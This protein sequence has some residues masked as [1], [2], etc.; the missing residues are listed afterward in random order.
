MFTSIEIEIRRPNVLQ[1]E[2]SRDFLWQKYGWGVDCSL[3]ESTLQIVTSLVLIG[4]D[5][6]SVVFSGSLSSVSRI[7]CVT[8][9]LFTIVE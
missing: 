4:I 1:C 9:S 8:S 7:G 6:F 3:F 5:G 2:N